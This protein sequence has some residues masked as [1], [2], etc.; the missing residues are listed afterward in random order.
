MSDI[1]FCLDVF[2]V[3][4]FFSSYEVQNRING[5]YTYSGAF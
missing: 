4:I 3:Y 2:T 5:L 1:V